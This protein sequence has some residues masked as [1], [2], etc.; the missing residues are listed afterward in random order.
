MRILTFNRADCDL[1]RFEGPSK[2]EDV[3]V[4]VKVE[5]QLEAERTAVVLHALCQEYRT[6]DLHVV[7]SNANENGGVFVI[8][9]TGDE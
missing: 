5:R 9:T 7:A 2:A 4:S 1:R 6:A 8:W 3:V